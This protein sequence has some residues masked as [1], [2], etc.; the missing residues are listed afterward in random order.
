MCQANWSTSWSKVDLLIISNTLYIV[1]FYILSFS[2]KS[3]I[4][5]ATSNN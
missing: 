4:I 1:K 5:K 3:A 2:K